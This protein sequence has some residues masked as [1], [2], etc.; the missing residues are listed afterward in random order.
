MELWFRSPSLT[1]QKTFCF[2]TTLHWISGY[3][4]PARVSS[5]LLRQFKAQELASAITPVERVRCK[6]CIF[7]LIQK[8]GSLATTADSWDP[9]A[10]E[11]P[12]TMRS[13]PVRSSSAISIRSLRLRPFDVTR[14]ATG[15]LLNRRPP[16]S[17]FQLGLVPSFRYRWLPR[18]IPRHAFLPATYAT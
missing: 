2:N 16:P 6:P 17:R 14:W 15:H 10:T 7:R 3:I 11:L 1:L 9:K 5:R 4:C 12:A 18:V 8:P 13:R